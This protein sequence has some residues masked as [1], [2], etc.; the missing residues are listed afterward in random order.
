VYIYRSLTEAQKGERYGGSGFLVAVRL[1]ENP[2]WW[3]C[4]VVTNWHVIQKA[5]SPVIRLNRRDGSVECIQTIAEQW[6]RHTDGDDV[7]VLPLDVEFENLRVWTI[8]SEDFVTPQRIFDEDIG[9][10]DDV[11][12]IGRF[13]NHEGRQKNSPAVRFGNIAMMAEEKIITD[14]GLA[15]EAFLVEV[16]SL[17]GYS[18]SAVLLYSPC[19]INDMS[20]R[21]D[22]RMKG[23]YKAGE[24][25][26]G[27][28]YDMGD[29]NWVNPKGPFLLGIDFCHIHRKASVRR[30]DGSKVKDGW[31]VEENTGMAG[32]IPAW[33]IAEVLDL[34]ELVAMREKDDR[35]LTEKKSKSGVSLDVA[36]DDDTPRLTQQ[37]FERA[38]KKASRRISSSRGK[39][40]IN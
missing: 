19:A 11:V 24:K 16:R 31:F 8:N 27:L 10:G 23:E 34:E 37:E 30:P 33:K 2:D 4:Y 17:P 39:T 26:E 38:L 3:D 5:K 40:R 7:A 12:M 20:E 22:G 9:I 28:T 1:K 36:D 13:V 29:L 35:E 6:F 18:G 15:Q 21:R 32:V 14:N 25:P